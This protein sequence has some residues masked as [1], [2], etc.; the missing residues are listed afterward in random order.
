MASFLFQS[1]LRRH[2]ARSAAALISLLA[3]GCGGG[4]GEATPRSLDDLL[5]RMGRIEALALPPPGPS[6]LE[7]SYDRTGGNRD[8]MT[9]RETN[10]QGR[11]TL[12][13]AEGPGY[14]SRIWTPGLAV[15]RWQFFFDGEST[16]RIDLAQDELFG[17]SFPFV[18]PLA[19]ESGGG[20]YSMMP[21]PF[22]RSLR[23]EV[24]PERLHED[25]RNY[26]HINTTRWPA[27]KGRIESWPRGL[28]PG[29]VQAVEALLAL[30]DAGPGSLRAAARSALGGAAPFDLAPGEARAVL[31]QD[32]AGTVAALAVA[33]DPSEN[34]RMKAHTM[35][36]HLRLRAWWDGDAEPGIDVPLGDF[37][38][39]PF[40]PRPYALHALGRVDDAYVSRLPMPFRNGARIEIRNGGDIPVRLTA[41]ATV[42]PAPP[43]RAARY[44]HAV[45]NATTTSGRPFVL[46]DLDG[47]GHY[48]G[49]FLTAVGQDGTWN[50]LEGDEFLLPDP[51]VQPGQFGT[52]LE[53]YF[54]GA[55]YYTGLFDRPWHS[56]ISK[57]AMRT[58]QIRLR[59]LDLTGF[60]ESL[61]V[62]I[63]FGHGNRSTGTMSGVVYVYLDRP[64][65]T[66][67]SPALEPL[68][69]RPPDRFEVPGFMASVFTMER[70]GLWEEAGLRSAALADRHPDRPWADRLRVRAADSRARAGGFEAVRGDLEQMAESADS[71]AAAQATDLLWMHDG[72]RRAL[73]GIHMR[74]RYRLQMNGEEVAA[75][76][77][78]GGLRVIRVEDLPEEV[79]WELEFVPTD[80]GAFAAFCLRT[81]EG[82]VTSAGPWET[83]G[84]VPHPEQ[85]PPERFEADAELPNM[86]LWEFEING[87]AGMQSGRQNL[88]LW[89]FWEDAPRVRAVHLR[90]TQNLREAIRAAGL[91]EPR[92]REEA[93]RRAYTVDP[94]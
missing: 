16:P 60:E 39:N 79:T 48:A 40:H 80:R 9:F 34:L 92:H 8:W 45:W 46:A 73:L 28:R 33:W 1:W 37:F 94:P 11:I 68:L 21:I 29:Q 13:D 74:G 24:V 36:R 6:Y 66:V 71:E 35:A 75:G 47:P 2:G 18:P 7:S 85:E 10:P 17:G 91:A 23:I 82:D 4:D 50:I 57:G 31:D 54:N 22:A 90:R 70:A 38:A 42:N 65:G 53:D 41:G 58:D 49:M 44:F 43:P 59:A 62:G 81:P 32:G 3:A 63:E 19:G 89:R 30:L 93:E 15:S 77:A 78:E 64:G 5:D 12:L 52:G 51:G 86:M 69:A 56:L 76:L 55:Y 67:L 26:F 87:Y 84:V 25:D 61:A 88:E 14:V 20:Q 72:E 83:V 27:R